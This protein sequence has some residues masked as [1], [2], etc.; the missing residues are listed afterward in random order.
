VGTQELQTLTVAEVGFAARYAPSA[1]NT[2]ALPVI[3]LNGSNGGFPP[4][5]LAESLR[6][7]GHAV[8]LLAYVNA[9]GMP[10]LP[11][12]AER[13]HQ[14]PLEYI[15]GA[16]DWLKNRTGKAVVLIGESR[17][18]ELALLL[19]SRRGGIAGVVAFAPSSVV[20]PAARFLPTDS[21]GPAWV[22][23]HG[24]LPFQEEV[25]EAGLSSVERFSRAID[26]GVGEARIPIER[27][28]G[29]VLLVAGE[30]DRIWPSGIMAD[31]LS[32]AA[33]RHGRPVIEQ[34]RYPDAGHLL[35]GP[36]PGLE[37]Y[38]SERWVV[39]FG[40][41]AAGNRAARDDAWSKTLS[42]LSMISSNHKA[43]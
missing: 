10:P 36:G 40:G 37:R 7:R 20:W 39:E 13:L 9:L 4:S 38:V 17:G 26:R 34:L 15:E 41:T 6:S 32:A 33:R 18:A 3:V 21:V 28:Q 35:M 43:R 14:V 22:T 30:D 8:L 31:S 16:I 23:R 27:V 29:R 12:V 11:G 25:A 5:I 2:S 42:F 19:A 24:A 1:N